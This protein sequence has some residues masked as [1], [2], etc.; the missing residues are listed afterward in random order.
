LRKIG[1][2]KVHVFDPSGKPKFDVNLCLRVVHVFDD[3]AEEGAGGQAGREG[4][5]PIAEAG[6]GDD[7]SAA[8]SVVAEARDGFG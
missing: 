8:E 6:D 1:A 7:A 5:E 3:F 2:R 4:C